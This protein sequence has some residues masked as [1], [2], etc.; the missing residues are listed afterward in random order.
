MFV[1]KLSP[2]GSGGLSQA[3]ERCKSQAGQAR[4]GYRTEHDR[5]RERHLPESRGLFFLVGIFGHP[6]FAIIKSSSSLIITFFFLFFLQKRHI[7]F[8]KGRLTQ[9]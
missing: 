6:P 1:S 3:G 9:R 7:L 4:G 2:S 5:D 8:F